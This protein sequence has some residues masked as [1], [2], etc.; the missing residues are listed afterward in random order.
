[1]S[2][3][4]QTRPADEI[5]V[6]DD[7]STDESPK[8][9]QTFGSRIHVIKTLSNRGNKS[10]ALE[11]G[12][13]F[14]RGDIIIITDADTLLDPEFVAAIIKQ[15][16]NPHVAAVSGYVKSIPYNW[17]TACRELEYLIAQD[18]HKKAIST[19]GALFVVPGCAGAFRV[20][21]FRRFITFDHDTIAED[22]DF[23]YKL[24]KRGYHIAF[25]RDAVVYTQDPH[26]ISSNIQQ[27]RR[28]YRGAWQ[29]LRKHRD[30]L[31]KPINALE[32]SMSYT[33]G[34]VF[35]LTLIIMPILDISF[36][37][38]TAIFYAL[39]S[40]TVGILGAYTRKRLDLLYYSPFFPFISLLSAYLFLEQLIATALVGNQEMRWHKPERTYID[41][42]TI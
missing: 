35:P 42:Q 5:I 3:L 38:L 31:I 24:M 27:V 17:L 25:T 15:F 29:N 10:Y 36:L 26:T 9:L 40:A 41:T 12:L 19:F 4:N 30:A 20:D 11:V 21:L 37:R 13:P 22:L 32:L 7:C 6:V 14:V 1:M 34:F 28:W 16:D 39:F 23:T 8:I 33:E 18:L 2:C